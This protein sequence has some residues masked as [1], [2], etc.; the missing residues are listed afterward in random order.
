MSILETYG[1]VIFSLLVPIIAWALNSLFKA[2]AKLQVALPHQFTFLVQQPLVNAEGKLLSPTQ[3]AK[4]DSFIIRN[5]GRETATKLEL[6][7][8]WKPMCLNPWPVRH[9]DEHIQ[10]RTAA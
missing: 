3:T 4:T 7:F 9:Y 10:S 6:V 8:D 5:A 1:K 2:K